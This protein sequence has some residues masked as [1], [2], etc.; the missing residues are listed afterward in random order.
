MHIVSGKL[1][2]PPFIKDGCGAEGNS[3]MY[4]IEL[5]EVIKDYRTDEKSYTN[6][7]AVFFAKTDGAKQFYDQAFAEGSFVVVAAEKIKAEVYNAENGNQYITL[8]L[9]NARLE[10][11]LPVE[12]AH[13][14]GGWGQPQQP[15][16]Q[17][18]QHQPRQQPQQ[19]QA[20]QYDDIDDSIPF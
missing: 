11:C 9:D 20:P 17:P 7:R 10:G 2:K 1:R 4:G 15:Q 6:Y 13:Q 14:Q 19:R 3:R 12:S 5:A 16:A 18:Q 8:N